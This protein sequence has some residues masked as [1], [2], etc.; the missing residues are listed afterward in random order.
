MTDDFGEHVL[1]MKVG[2]HARE[3]LEEIIARKQ[4]EI[5]DEGFALWGYG[6]NTCH[7]ARVRD[8][9]SAGPIRLV[10]QGMKSM[11]AAQP[12]RAKTYST[13]GSQW[14]TVPRG[15]NVLGSQFALAISNLEQVE[16][17]LDL[18]ATRVALGATSGR[19]GTAYIKGRVDKACLVPGALDPDQSK[20]VD[21]DL[22][23]DVI[24]PFAVFL[25]Y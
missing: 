16:A 18:G 12:R 9:A 11:H 8:F 21:I 24:E 23:A 20:I 10:M 7:P 2:V 6:G 15:I 3:S 25:H 1:F 22:V 14:R 5:E 17:Q 19:S 13:D 4:R